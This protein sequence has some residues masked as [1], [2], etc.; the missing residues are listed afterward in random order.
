MALST[1][2]RCGRPVVVDARYCSG[3]GLRNPAPSTTIRVLWIV[4][5]AVFA[6]ATLVMLFRTR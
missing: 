6:L 1:C 5:L 4:I 3:C 2:R